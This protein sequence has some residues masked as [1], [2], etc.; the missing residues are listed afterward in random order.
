MLN[1][2]A[3]S[4]VFFILFLLLISSSFFVDNI[5]QVKASNSKTITVTFRTTPTTATV[6]KAPLKYN[7]D[8]AF[9][10]QMDDGSADNYENGFKYMYGGTSSLLNESYGGKYFTDGSGRSTALASRPFR[11]DF[12]WNSRNYGSSLVELHAS[13]NTFT[14]AKLLDAYTAGFDVLNHSWSHAAVTTL[15]ADYVYPY[16]APHNPSTIDYDYELS[17]NEAEVASHGV[18]IAPLAMVPPAGD[19]GYINPAFARTYKMVASESSSFTYSGGTVAVDTGGMN[20]TSSVDLDHL[21]AYRYFYDDSRFVPNTATVIT[22]PIDTLASRSRGSN[23]YWAIGFTHRTSVV[24]GGL[25]ES[26]Y[27]SLMNHIATTYGRDGDDSIWMAPAEEVY[28]Y[29]STKQNTAVSTNTVGN[30]MTIT[31]DT[32]SVPAL[33]REALSLLVSSDAEISSIEFADG[34]FTATSSNTSTGLINVDWGTVYTANDFTRVETLVSTAESSRAQSDI[35]IA[36]TYVNMLPASVEKNNFT[37]RLGNIVVLGR[38]WLIDLGVNTAQRLQDT[39]VGSETENLWWNEINLVSS[40]SAVSTSGV[41]YDTANVITDLTVVLPQSSSDANRWQKPGSINEGQTTVTD[42]D[43]AYPNVKMQK[44]LYVYAAVETSPIIQIHHLDPAKKYKITV[45]GSTK[46]SSTTK[47]TSNISV[48]GVSQGP[49]QHYNNTNTTLIF[50]SVSPTVDGIIEIV[51]TPV[52]PVWSVTPINVIDISEVTP[53]LPTITFNSQSLRSQGSGLV[54]YGYTITDDNSDPIALM[55]Y[56]YSSTGL[57]SGEEATATPK[58]SDGLH[59][60]ISSLTSSP[61]GVAHDFVWDAITDLVGQ[62]GSFYLRLRPQN[63]SSDGSYSIATPVALDFKSPTQSSITATTTSSTANITWTTQEI[64]YGLVEYGTTDS[65]GSSAG[66]LSSGTAV[67]NHDFDLSSLT[68]CTTYHYRVSSRDSVGNNTVSSD[69]TMHT[70]GCPDPVASPVAGLYNSTQSV[71]LSATGSSS[72]RYSASSTPADCSADTLYS[73]A[74]TVATTSTIYARA[75]DISNNSTTASFLYT[76]DTV[77]PSTPVASPGAGTFNSTQSVT[78][79]AAGSDSIRYSTSSTPSNCSAGTLY[80]GAISVS[81]DQTI[82]TRACDTAGNSSTASFGYVIDT[83]APDSAVASPVAGIY[84]STQSVTLS[85][86]GSTSIR[87]STSSTPADCSAGTLYTGA[88]SVVTTSTIYVRACDGAGN[89]S[90]TSFAYTIDTTAPDAPVASP[91]SGTYNSTQSVTLSASGSDSIRYSTS[92]TPAN[93]SSGTL[94]SGAITVATTSTIY[95][96]ACDAA[97]NSSTASFEYVIDTVAPSAPTSTVSAGSYNTALSIELSAVGSDYIKYSTSGSVLNCSSGTLYSAA[98]DL[99]SSSTLYARACDNAGNSTTA[100]FVY[101]VDTENPSTPVA[102][103]AAGTHA[104]TQSVT[105][106]A[107][108]STSIRYS[109]VGSPANCS[110]G[111]L[112]YSAISV[113]ADST[114]YARAC[115]DVGNSSTSSFEYTI[116]AD[117]TPAPAPVVQT[118]TYGSSGSSSYSAPVS[119]IKITKPSSPVKD[120]SNTTAPVSVVKNKNNV[121]NITVKPG[122]VSSIEKLPNNIKINTS[123]PNI[124]SLQEF[125]SN[126]SAGPKAKALE[127]HGIT[128]NFGPLTKSALAEWQKANGLK[129]DG[130]MGPK[131]KAKILEVLKK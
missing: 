90:T 107:S 105:L 42:G 116:T 49:Y 103:P 124:K 88:I 111:S 18:T 101:I 27:E 95:A 117:S 38:R 23:K 20:V 89:S 10:F 72:I 85:A 36:T 66:S 11:G 126:S 75:C 24:S 86:S 12:V 122:T 8:F 100:S 128:N 130:I 39:V 61:A 37:S 28:D 16:P 25:S 50:S 70:A 79:S 5:N 60:G 108:G 110:S 109:L 30:V 26:N 44:G 127:K 113:S 78:L 120:I 34:E 77:A 80:S 2:R 22:T 81:T 121:N 1:I 106:S 115:D 68:A 99:A 53:A 98:I 46:H 83:S 31:L 91:V 51:M 55:S 114:I 69:Q 96:R 71:T 6:A 47:T 45:F 65:Y 73:G 41:L 119:N 13:A 21:F 4:I 58:S 15:G 93:C 62:E 9:S 76:I 92:G 43:G 40:N 35:D 59:D 123:S 82:Y 19:H 32:S 84:N 33:R 129:A 48:Q 112:Y 3:K 29:L 97:G 125:L 74:I 94:Y 54:D 52:N 17:Q 56:Q 7:K 104:G 64:A 131:T 63:L 67:L 57:F 118:R 102:S 14:W 87:Y